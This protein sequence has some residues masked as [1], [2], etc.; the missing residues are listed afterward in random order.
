MLG[1]RRESATD[2]ASKLQ[3]WGVI[4]YERGK[5]A[6][7]DRS[8]VEALCCECYA[9]VKKPIGYG[10]PFRQLNTG[11]ITRVRTM[12]S[13]AVVARVAVFRPKNSED[14]VDLENH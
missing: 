6:V 9:T 12:A 7:L 2:A 4:Q 1:V 10:V 8:K 11:T 3:G 13:N 5:I 14:R